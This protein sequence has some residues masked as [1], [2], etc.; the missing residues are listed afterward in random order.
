MRTFLLFLVLAATWLLWSG[1][2]EPLMLGFGVFSCGLC[3]VVA[4]RM[5]GNDFESVPLGTWGR[6]LLY[7]P[8]IIWEIVKSNL[9]V[10]RVVLSPSLPIQPKLVRVKASQKTAFGQV[11][12]ANSI[13]AT[14]GTISLDLRDGEILVHALTQETADGLDGVM[15]A[16]CTWVE[17]A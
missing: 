4:M 14:P 15:D 3:T 16:K 12:Y 6:L 9:H 17:G 10:A 1:H 13:T 5:R 11:L 8:W 7:Q 2:V